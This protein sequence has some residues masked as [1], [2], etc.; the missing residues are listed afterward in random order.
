MRKQRKTYVRPFK[1][2][3]KER[4]AEEAR[5]VR[6]YGLRNKRELW[7]ARKI[8][9]GF[10]ERARSLFS[11]E[12]GR[13]ELFNKI[14]RMGLLKGNI[15]LDDVLGLKVENLLERRLQTIV[16]RKGLASTVKQAR[17]IITHGHIAVGDRVVDV[18]G[19][20]VD[21]EEEK[22]VRYAPGSPLNDP[23]HPLRK[24]KEPEKEEEVKENG[25][26]KEA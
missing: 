8:I 9:S 24:A 19:Y 15:T 10:R 18:P 21:V 13:E 11:Q 7:K 25:E 26:G 23:D 3:D 17:Q 6:D 2:W 1:R 16:Y 12:T 5:L 20:F 14:R 4:I 22:Q